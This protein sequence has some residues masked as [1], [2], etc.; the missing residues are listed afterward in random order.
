[1]WF[2]PF[3]ET[4]SSASIFGEDFTGQKVIRAAELVC[5]GL[6]LH[7]CILNCIG[8]LYAWREVVPMDKNY[9]CPHP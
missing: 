2:L 1:M 7:G 5:R 6:H 4:E 9:I 8:H 3:G